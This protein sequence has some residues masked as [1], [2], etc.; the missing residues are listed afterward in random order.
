MF[1]LNLSF[2]HFAH[3]AKIGVCHFFILALS[4]QNPD[5]AVGKHC[6]SCQK[7]VSTALLQR[8]VEEAFSPKHI[9][10]LIRIIFFFKH[11]QVPP[12]LY[13]EMGE[14]INKGNT[15]ISESS[16]SAVSK[17]YFKQFQE[18]F[19][20]FLRSRSEELVVGGRMVL[21]LLGR[22]GPDHVDR[23]N[24]FFWELLSRSLAI[25]VS[26][27]F[28]FW[29]SHTCNHACMRLVQQF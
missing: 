27:V 1:C 7:N 16:P 24:S 17:A 5:S 2:L 20:L 13:N 14:S 22:I 26:Q 8:W 4:N 12:T 9:V 21:I 19:T 3:Q 25:L 23:G 18:D 28:N 15:Y 10:S 11:L 29:N 6:Y